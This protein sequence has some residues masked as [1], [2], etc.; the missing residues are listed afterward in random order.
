MKLSLSF[1]SMFD[2]KSNQKITNF[3][4]KSCNSTIFHHPSFLSY[5][6]NRFGNSE[7]Y[8][9]WEKGQHIFAVMPVGIF[10]DKQKTTLRSP[11]GASFGGIVSQGCLKL[12]DSLA[13]V[14]E[15]NEF[16]KRESVHNVVI[17][18][19]PEIYFSKGND[20]LYFA[21]EKSGYKLVSRDLFNVVDISSEYKSTWN[22]Y[23]GR[24]RT[25]VRKCSPNFEIFSNVSL[26]DFY[27]ILLEDKERLN[28]IP[29][30][31]LE[32]L[33]SIKEKCED[34]I[35]TDIAIHKETKAKVGICYMKVTDD[36]VMTFYMSQE[37]S[38]LRLNGINILVDYGIQ[39]SG[40]NGFSLFDF[41]SSTVGYDIHNIG[42]ANFK[43]SFGAISSSRLTYQW[44]NS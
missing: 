42:V 41:G 23:E 14:D 25:A 12:K 39:R 43:E 37:T 21:L 35:W 3:L 15:L 24:A 34:V 30:H 4:N 2:A 26:E 36:V 6:G 20:S 28:A 18:F 16:C 5:H 27:P 38:A 8:L 13:I 7:R 33:L 10:N 17:T 44:S 22:N 29:T 11:Y 1:H 40:E 31:S 9:V 19:P 32:E